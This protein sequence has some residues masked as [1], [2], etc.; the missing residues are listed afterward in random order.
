MAAFAMAGI[1]SLIGLLSLKY[2]N[3]RP[4]HRFIFL[5]PVAL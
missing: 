3:Q 5:S 1:T 2:D 4:S